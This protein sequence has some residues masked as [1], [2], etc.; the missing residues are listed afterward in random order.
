MWK[1]TTRQ[2]NELDSLCFISYKS[3]M[4]KEKRAFSTQA[5]SVQSVLNGWGF[6]N[7]LLPLSYYVSTARF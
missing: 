4:A 7:S 2:V 5:E 6:D 1:H 3:T